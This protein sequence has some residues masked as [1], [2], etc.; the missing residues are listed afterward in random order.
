MVIKKYGKTISEEKAEKT[1]K[2][3]QI[4]AEVM[5]YGV[6]QKQILRLIYLLALELEDR[7]QL[8]LVTDLVKQLEE[9]DDKQSGLIIR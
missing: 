9:Q 2:C 5:D 7:D 8:Q 6:S 1:F 4:I 3:R